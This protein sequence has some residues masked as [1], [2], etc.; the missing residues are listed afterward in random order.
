MLPQRYQIY[1]IHSKGGT[2]V[3][4][5]KLFSDNE[6]KNKMNKNKKFGI[7]FG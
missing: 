6:H 5:N 4:Y 7:R 2:S 3:Q 1:F